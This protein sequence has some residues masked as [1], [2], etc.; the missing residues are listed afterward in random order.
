MFSDDTA[1]SQNDNAEDRDRD[2]EEVVAHMQNQEGTDREKRRALAPPRR[3]PAGR[4]GEVALSIQEGTDRERRRALA[5][6]KRMDAG[7]R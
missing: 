4:W 7:A 2:Y 5:Q 3:S 6:P 1:D